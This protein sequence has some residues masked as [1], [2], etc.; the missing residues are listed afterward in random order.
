MREALVV[1][2][3]DVELGRE[4][5]VG[6]ELDLG[7]LGAR[8]ELGGHLLDASEDGVLV[9]AREGE[10]EVEVVVEALF[11]SFADEEFEV[12]E[13]VAEACCPVV[14]VGLGYL[15]VVDGERQGPALVG[16]EGGG[17]VVDEGG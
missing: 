4:C 5:V 6:R 14:G 2:E 12:V 10:S 11:G 3:L 8:G 1:V 15:V 17:H 9:A 7:A 13:A 16:G